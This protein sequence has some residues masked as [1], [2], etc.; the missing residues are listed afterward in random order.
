MK[1]NSSSIFFIVMFP[2]GRKNVTLDHITYYE[3]YLNG[4]S[5]YL[6]HVIKA[7]QTLSSYINM[8]PRVCKDSSLFGAY[9]GPPIP[10]KISPV[11]STLMRTITTFDKV[12]YTLS[13]TYSVSFTANNVG[14]LI[15]VSNPSHNLET[16]VTQIPFLSPPL[17]IINI[18]MMETLSLPSLTLG[19][20]VWYMSHPYLDISPTLS[21]HYSST[22]YFH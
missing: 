14:Y 1:E 15:G 17:N 20:L 11:G 13:T 4:K 5:Y 16:H 3:P 21:T 10:P 9:Q 12:L 18:P 6:L 8:V 7:N 19:K 2:H 22:P